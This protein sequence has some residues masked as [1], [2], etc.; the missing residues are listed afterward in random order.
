M[1]F[2][3]AC[4]AGIFTVMVLQI[5]WVILKNVIEFFQ[6]NLEEENVYRNR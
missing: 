1:D 4:F 5:C 6:N 3:V 2:I